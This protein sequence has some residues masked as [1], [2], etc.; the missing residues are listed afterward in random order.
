[1]FA[2]R[3]ASLAFLF[4]FSA[5]R[6]NDL[7]AKIRAVTDAPEYKAA[8]W[9]I[10]VVDAKTGATVYEQNPD[11]LFLPASVTKLFTCATALAELGSDYRFVT[12]VYVRG[13]VKDKVLDGDLVLV[14]S[15]DLTFGGRRGKSEGIEF[16]NNDHTYANSGLMNSTLT[17]TNPLYALE[18]L[19]KQIAAEIREVKG[20]VLIDDRLFVRTRSSG[21]GPEIVSPILVNDN[22]VDVIVSPGEKEG[23]PAIVKARPETAYI[24]MDADVRTSKA[25]G[26]PNISVEATGSGQFMV[27]GR[28]PVKAEPTV[29]IYPVDE[30]VLF[31]RALFIESLRKQGVKIAASLHRPRRFEMPGPGDKLSRIAEYRSEP[32]AETIKVTLKVSHNLYASTLPVLVGLR[33]QD[34]TAEAGLRQQGRLLKGL[35]VDPTTVSFAGGAGGASADSASPRA[36]VNLLRAMAKHPAGADYFKAMP[37]LGVDGTLSESV[38]KESPARGKV[39]GK[40]GT[41]AWY[42]AQNERLLLRSKALAGELETE[43]GTK[44]YFAMFLNDMPLAQGGTAAQQGKV[45]GKLCEIIYK[46]DP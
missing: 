23:D 40:T 7:A 2:L 12:P 32:L 31:A 29:R 4:T 38:A 41:L 9:G 26:N 27:R 42:D 44:L 1:M 13:E 5:V 16:A 10:L 24:Q 28:I 19:A 36:T 15:G 20:E 39:R 11:K 46:N 17:D 6:A 21:S 43:K 37:I 22:V 25:G 18:Q 33:H 30:P 14:A 3:I 34:G 8:R 35:G 45:I